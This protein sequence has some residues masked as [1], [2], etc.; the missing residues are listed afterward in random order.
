MA[1]SEQGFKTGAIDAACS[2]KFRKLKLQYEIEQAEAFL[3]DV[4]LNNC[5]PTRASTRRTL[6][7]TTSY[8]EQTPQMKLLCL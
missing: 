8:E 7:T 5:D 1:T 3:E 4:L 6:S 2:E